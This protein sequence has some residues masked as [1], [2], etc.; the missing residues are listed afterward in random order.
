M[1]ITP[2]FQVTI[3]R[4]SSAVC[5]ESVVGV[6]T[7]II[8]HRFAPDGCGEHNQQLFCVYCSRL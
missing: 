7:E 1:G 3:D 2:T 4:Q 6:V 8:A 5:Q